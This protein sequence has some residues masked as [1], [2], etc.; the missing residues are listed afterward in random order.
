MAPLPNLADE[1]DL[2]DAEALVKTLPYA[3]PF[4]RIG[5]NQLPAAEVASLQRARLAVSMAEALR[6]KGSLPAVIVQD[7]LTLA[8]VS[9]RAFYEHFR[10]KR[11]CFLYAYR[12]TEAKRLGRPK[13]REHQAHR[14][15]RAA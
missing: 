15:Q 6:T 10:S 4:K 8:G 7:V 3:G 11:A 12:L 2:R 5:S 9:R 1:L 13:H 14:A